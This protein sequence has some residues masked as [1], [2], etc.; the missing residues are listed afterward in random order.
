MNRHWNK[1]I[2]HN[3]SATTMFAE[4]SKLRPTRVRPCNQI[5]ILRDDQPSAGT[6]ARPGAYQPPSFFCSDQRQKVA[7]K[8]GTAIRGGAYLGTLASAVIRANL[9]SSG[10]FSIF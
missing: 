2:H 4:G 6:D 7:E 5:D 8:A 3:F 1:R 9:T 10:S